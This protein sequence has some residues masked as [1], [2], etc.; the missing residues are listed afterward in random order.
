M[1]ATYSREYPE[2]RASRGAN[3]D[4]ALDAVA[5]DLS[6][7]PHFPLQA[8]HYD[9]VHIAN[10]ASKTMQC[11]RGAQC[12]SRVNQQR[13]LACKAWPLAPYPCS[14]EDVVD[15]RLIPVRGLS[16]H[17]CDRGH[18]SARRLIVHGC[19]SL[20]IHITVA[21]GRIG[22]MN[23][24]HHCESNS[25]HSTGCHTST[26]HERGFVVSAST[27]P[28]TSAPS[29]VAR[30][31]HTRETPEGGALAWPHIDCITY[32]TGMLS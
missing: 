9:A 5:E 3:A 8:K 29:S 30:G 23:Y 17:A 1:H 25:T 21:A 7:A 27:H 2:P 18:C 32:I 24:R 20:I 14:L 19:I 26:G 22:Y 4:L 10:D 28:A 15:S 31:H 11:I 12:I 13:A 6:F 16:T